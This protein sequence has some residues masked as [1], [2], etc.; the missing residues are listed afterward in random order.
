MGPAWTKYGFVN[1][2]N[3]L[4]NWYDNDVIGIDTGITM[5]MAENTRSGFVWND[6]HEESGG[7]PRHGACR[8]QGLLTL[9]PGSAGPS[10]H[11]LF[12]LAN[13]ENFA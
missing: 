11:R 10:A 4:K 1:A 2:F 7:E 6:F 13:R 3:P 9:V 5:V 12:F 8:L